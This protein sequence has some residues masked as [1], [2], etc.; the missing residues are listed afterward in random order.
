MKNMWMFGITGLSLFVSG[1]IL[2]PKLDPIEPQE[3]SW[4]MVVVKGEAS[5]DCE[6][7]GADFI[8]DTLELL[9]EKSAEGTI[10]VTLEDIAM[11]AQLEDNIIK[12]SGSQSPEPP[13]VLSEEQGDEPTGDPEEDPQESEEQEEIEGQ[14]EIEVPEGS[15]AD[16]T[17]TVDLE[18]Q[19]LEA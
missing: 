9:L 17:I 12:A 5:A 8:G 2:E 10:L 16:E 1:C 6:E 13:E 3:G 14:E 19:L 11:E 15:A 18:G 4:T 7:S